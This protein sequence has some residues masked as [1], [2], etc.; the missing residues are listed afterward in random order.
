MLHLIIVNS[1][2]HIA[3]H[4]MLL[5]MCTYFYAHVRVRS[6]RDR[7]SSADLLCCACACLSLLHY[8][9]LT[10]KSPRSLGYS[11][12]YQSVI[13]LCFRLF[14][15]PPPTPLRILLLLQI[16]NNKVGK[17]LSYS[18]T[19]LS[20]GPLLR[21]WVAPRLTAYH[22]LS[23]GPRSGLQ[24]PFES[25]TQDHSYSALTPISQPKLTL[26]LYCV[27]SG[28]SKI[29]LCFLLKSEFTILLSAVF[30]AGKISVF[31]YAST[32]Q[33]QI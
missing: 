24:C 22:T 5:C 12:H 1:Y 29:F 27:R 32:Y 30:S 18:V 4:N 21:L 13:P 25:V 8:L 26:L 19:V 14:L 17:G 15:L 2:K 23:P 33:I 28:Y 11:L 10:E 6:Y 31:S 20:T 9:C 16:N 7:R 3:H